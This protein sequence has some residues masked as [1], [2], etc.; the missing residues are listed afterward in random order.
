MSLANVKEKERGRDW[1]ISEFMFYLKDTAAI[2][3]QPG[4]ALTGMQAGSMLPDLI[5][6]EKMKIWMF[7]KKCEIS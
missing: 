1:Q 7:F 4:G 5:F 2:W 6:Q 3:L